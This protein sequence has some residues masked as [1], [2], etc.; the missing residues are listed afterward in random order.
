MLENS[1]PSFGNAEQF[2]Q[3]FIDFTMGPWL[4]LWEFGINRQLILADKYFAQ[5][6]RQALL[7]G[8]MTARSAAVVGYVNAGLMSVDE[9]RGLEDL[10]KRGGKADELREPQNITGKPTV[11]G[12]APAEDTPPPK[13]V[14]ST[15]DEPRRRA[16]AITTESAA[17]VL[18]K[19]VHAAQ[20]A[21]VKFAADAPGWVLWVDTFYTT[22]HVLVMETML[23]DEPTARGYVALQRAELHDGIAVTEA[24]TPD[25]LAGLAL[26][27]GPKAA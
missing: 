15:E 10:P 13:K 24:W 3:A 26:D 1:D 9:G 6:K 25:Y 11:E 5:F 20:K 21:A 4:A 12:G 16:R 27:V 22:H 2:N 19:E 8:N 17:R 7:R 14:P 23:V 18:R